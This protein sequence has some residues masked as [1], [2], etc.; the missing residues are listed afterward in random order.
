MESLLQP[1]ILAA[2]LLVPVAILGA[3]ALRAYRTRVHAPVRTIR[4]IGVGGAGSRVLNRMIQSS[5]GGVEFIACN[6][7]AESLEASVA[8]HKL[9][10]GTTVTRGL[11]AGGDP[12]LGERAAQED[13]QAIARA[14]AGSDI[15]V[16]VAG[17]G[18]GTGSGSAPVIAS[19]AREQGALTIGIVTKPFSFEGTRRAIVAAQGGAELRNKVDALI[20]VR[21]DR[22]RDIVPA[23]STMLDAFRLVD[24]AVQ[25]SVQGIVDVPAVTGFIN[26]GLA[27]VRA[28]MKDGG[29]AVMGIG[30]AS[31]ENRAVEAARQA[32]SAGLLEDSI[33]GA[34]RVLMNVRGSAN[35]RLDEVTHAADV[36]RAAVDSNAN[37]AFGANIGDS[38]GDDVQVTVIATGFASA[39]SGR[40]GTDQAASDEPAMLHEPE[41][42]RD[43]ERRYDR[44]SAL[45]AGSALRGGDGSEPDDTEAAL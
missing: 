1:Q 37:M 2:A 15:V 12:T 33:D 22:V 16:I 32:V 20:T 18:G 14:L 42:S 41:S 43:R 4:V 19:V 10:I 5:M 40:R 23:N 36:V 38:L 28:V 35:L 7:D 26:L 24:E 45:S 31:G 44:R 39:G 9:Q 3:A 34:T 21:N 8:Q 25:H 13:A 17:L 29:A 11:G 30:R 27:D 6:T